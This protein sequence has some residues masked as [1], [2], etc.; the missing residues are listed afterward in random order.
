V[1]H[2]WC[3]ACLVAVRI[4]TD[5][6]EEARRTWARDN[7]RDEQIMKLG[8]GTWAHGWR[9]PRALL[10][11]TPCPL[12]MELRLQGQPSFTANGASS[13]M[14]TFVFVEAAGW[15]TFRCPRLQL[16]PFPGIPFPVSFTFSLI[17]I[18]I[19]S[20]TFLGAFF[21]PFLFMME[22]CN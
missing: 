6:T 3:E 4:L 14:A 21:F 9:W 1:H 11:C 17:P 7:E 12:P 16:P 13:S 18:H 10:I 22:F 2:I 15:P 19:F 20:G 8:R 5:S